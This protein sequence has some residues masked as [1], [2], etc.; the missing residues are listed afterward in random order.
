MYERLILPILLAKRLMLLDVSIMPDGSEPLG[1]MER[2][3]SEIPLLLARAVVNMYEH[4]WA[5]A[6]QCELRVGERPVMSSWFP[7]GPLE[8]VYETVQ[9]IPLGR[10]TYLTTEGL[11]LIETLHGSRGGRSAF[12]AVRLVSRPSQIES[13]AVSSLHRGLRRVADYAPART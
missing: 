3:R 7:M 13:W 4:D 10:N 2:E 8:P 5:M 9:V 11:V 12:G 6:E 1:R